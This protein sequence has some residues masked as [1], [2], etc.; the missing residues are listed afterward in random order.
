MGFL[1][2]LLTNYHTKA[3]TLNTFVYFLYCSSY[4]NLPISPPPLV[5]P[6]TSRLSW[7]LIFK[8]FFI[9][10]LVSITSTMLTSH[11]TQTMF[12][13]NRNVSRY[14]QMSPGRQNRPLLKT[15]THVKMRA[16][17]RS[18]TLELESVDLNPDSATY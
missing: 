8:R 10:S 4:E 15:T 13:P 18:P 2:F 6:N 16:I 7:D 17:K 5:Y 12:V 3:Q 9:K 11:H 14:Y 1:P